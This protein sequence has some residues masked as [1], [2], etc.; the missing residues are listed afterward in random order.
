[1]PLQG[2]STMRALATL[3]AVSLTALV[4]SGSIRAQ[5]P[6]HFEERF[7]INAQY[8]GAVTKTFKGLGQ[9]RVV[10]TTTPDGTFGLEINGS[11]QNP[12]TREILRLNAQAD[13]RL[14]G[15]QIERRRQKLDLSEEAKR[16]ENLVTHNLPFV[17]LA[18]FQPLPKG[19]DPE[20]VHYRFDGREYLL[21]YA[22]VEGTVEATL[23]EGGTM[24]GKMFL[25]GEYGRPP[26]GLT[27]ARMVGANHLVFSLVIDRGSTRARGE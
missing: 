19:A 18:R 5:A 14:R 16:Y 17:Y 1:M 9:G 11:L 22:T 10:Y 4:S 27:K 8:R 2:E 7:I 24:I 3:F 15:Q 21:R 13:F 23:F 6:A 26:K 25:F 20:E 12:D